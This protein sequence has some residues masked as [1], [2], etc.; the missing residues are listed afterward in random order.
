MKR[1]S[2]L[3]GSETPTPYS[4]ARPRPHPW[5]SPVQTQVHELSPNTGGPASP[6]IHHIDKITGRRA[7]VS[8]VGRVLVTSGT[9]I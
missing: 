4:T 6:A 1:S 2:D 7:E 8:M 5:S 3:Q 9:F